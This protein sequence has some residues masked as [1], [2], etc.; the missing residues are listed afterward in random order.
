MHTISG[1]WPR[2]FKLLPFLSLSVS[3]I[4]SHTP[5]SQFDTAEFTMPH[6]C[7][8]YVREVAIE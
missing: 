8:G 5:Y 2:S 6:S 3:L 7:S 4:L 1:D